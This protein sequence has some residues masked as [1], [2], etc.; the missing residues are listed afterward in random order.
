MNFKVDPTSLE[1]GGI[2][3]VSASI[4]N[5]GNIQ[6]NDVEIQ[7]TG[8]SSETISLY[9]SISSVKVGRLGINAVYDFSFPIA[10]NENLESGNYPVT[11]KIL[12]K[13]DQNGCPRSN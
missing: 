5:T 1:P 4:K 9:N 2:G 10:A 3:K 8:L 12:Y 7:I 13:N 6:M 11:F